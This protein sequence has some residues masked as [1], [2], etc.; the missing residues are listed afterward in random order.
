MDTHGILYIPHN[1]KISTAYTPGHSNCYTK[2]ATCYKDK[3]Q[4]EGAMRDMQMFSAHSDKAG[5]GSD[6][7]NVY[8]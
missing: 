8:K 7:Y 5:V 1:P 2:K 3:R 6:I 4:E